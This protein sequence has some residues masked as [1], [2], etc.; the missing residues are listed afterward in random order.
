MGDVTSVN[1]VDLF[2][3]YGGLNASGRLRIYQL[4]AITND[5]SNPYEFP[6]EN[7]SNPF[8]M[9]DT[10]CVSIKNPFSR[11]SQ[12]NESGISSNSI[13]RVTISSEIAQDKLLLKNY[14]IVDWAS[15]RIQGVIDSVVRKHSNRYHLFINTSQNVPFLIP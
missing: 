4:N 11:F 13:W 3:S 10:E 15:Q 6:S 5:V 1:C 12:N 8:L 2:K 7:A 14:A 9:L